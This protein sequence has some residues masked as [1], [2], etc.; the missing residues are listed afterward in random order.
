MLRTGAPSQLLKR[1]SDGELKVPSYKNPIKRLSLNAS[2]SDV[3]IT[4][5][6]DAAA[7]D[8][9]NSSNH[10]DLITR[11]LLKPFKIPIANYT[12]GYMS[13]SLGIRRSSLRKPLHDPFESFALVLFYPPEYTEQEKLTMKQEEIQVH[14][15]VDPVLSKILRYTEIITVRSS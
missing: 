12:G 14:V 7:E 2:L 1:R 3:S 8:I 11:I 5:A 15:V 10:E 6:A 9:E 4:E 13:K